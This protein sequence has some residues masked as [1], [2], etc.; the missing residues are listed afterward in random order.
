VSRKEHWDRVYVKKA[1]SDLSWFQGEPA[2][3]LSLIRQAGLG[4]DDWLIDVGGGTSR[5]LAHLLAE[6][7][8]NL[9]ILDISETGLETARAQLGDRA[10]EV[11][12]FECDVLDFEPPHRWAL[13]HDRAV[14]HFLTSPDDRGRYC[15]VL[16][17]GLEPS[18]HLMLS[19]FALDGPPRCSGLEVTRHSPESL[20]ALLGPEYRLL[21]SMNESHRTPTGGTQSFLYAWFQRSG[22]R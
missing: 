11:E 15:S 5:L 16:N 21:G 17:R 10:A 2:T 4:P 20:Q 18:G 12:W 8:R 6:G 1:S 14:F 19:T 13:W 9:S 22:A 3:S 7:Y